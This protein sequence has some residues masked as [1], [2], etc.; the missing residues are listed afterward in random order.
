MTNSKN[1]PAPTWATPNEGKKVL[2]PTGATLPTIKNNLT[3]QQFIN[4]KI[5]HMKQTMYAALIT[6]TIV[7]LFT[8]CKKR[9]GGNDTGVNFGTLEYDGKT[10]KFT[11]GSYQF[12]NGNDPRY[13]MVTLSTVYDFDVNGV[14]LEF[15]K[16]TDGVPTGSFTYHNYGVGFNPAT[17]FGGYYMP[18]VS[19]FMQSGTVTL[20]KS[21]EEYTVKF[22]TILENG[23]QLKGTFKG[24]LPPK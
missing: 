16:N 13:I 17:N 5:K 4:L 9:G 20:S 11:N 8:A 1:I 15:I 24:K 10:S 7:T 19:V 14:R 2:A 23:K 12:N 22:D 6:C 3:M 21:G 18:S